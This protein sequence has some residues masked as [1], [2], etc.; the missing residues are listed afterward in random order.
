MKLYWN[1]RVRTW[2]LWG[3]HIGKFYIGV[4]KEAQL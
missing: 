3:L 2:H 1:T 4:S